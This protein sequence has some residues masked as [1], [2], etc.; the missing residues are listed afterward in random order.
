M[1]TQHMSSQ[2]KR[3][4]LSF[5]S[6]LSSFFLLI[7]NKK[8]LYFIGSFFIL[9]FFLFPVLRLLYLS[10]QSDTGLTAA[11]YTAVLAEK[12]T[13]VTLKNTIYIVS[14]STVL[15]VILG[16][17]MAWLVAYT[18]VRGKKWMQLFIF[19]PFIIPSYVITLAWVQF[20]G[21]SGLFTMF[22][23]IF[24][25]EFQ[26]FNLYSIWGIIFIMG[27]SHY[28]L[29]YLLTVTV[30]R[31][32]PRDFEH[33]SRVSGLSK[34]G[35][36]LKVSLPLALPG[37]T[38]GG[39]L[40]FLANLD[41]FGIPAFLGIPSNIKV[42]S[43]Y[44]YEQIVGF[45]P[46]AFARGAAL[47]VLLG[48]IALIGTVIQWFLLRRSKQFETVSEDTEPRIYLSNGFQKVMEGLVWLFLLTTSLIPL[49]SM[50][51]TSF[52]RAYGLEMKLENMSFKNYEFILFDSPKA[53]TAMMNSLTLAVVT[54][55]VCMIIG[56]FI[57]YMRTRQ[58]AV[59][60]KIAELF[61]SIPYAL[62]GTVLALMMIFAW[63]EPIPNWN[64]GIYGSIWILFIAYIT[65]FLFLQV[66]GSATALQQ[67]ELSV[68][69]AAQVCGTNGFYK[70]KSIL[71]PLLLPGIMS[72]AL[73]VFLFSLTELTLSSLLWSS[74]SETIGLLIFN[75][76]QAG[77]S[78][79][80]TAFSTLIVIC[81]M[82]GCI[83]SF[84]L[85]KIWSRRVLKNR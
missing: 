60:L 15:A 82:L 16:V 25:N 71:I 43:T 3:K 30:F 28:P 79:H 68:E 6:F 8:L 20:T 13:W 46:A 67:V 40:A 45:G 58:P 83:L 69:E 7:K 47:S 75:F 4:G 48:V 29:V 33:A 62:P 14:G 1:Q 18:N 27:I 63:M 59:Y 57:A 51:M 2:K 50:A 26:S 49:I 44:I 38:S 12:E 55:L 17:F 85:Q 5:S 23:N 78:T 65:R 76:E 54:A 41:N 84:I 9:V 74:G 34:T 53:K 22:L 42:L 61:I 77:Y 72:G 70:W 19:L 39:L 24:T 32:I 56:T 35:T 10:F 66:R 36:F 80:S 52:I 21:S 11:N 31:K 64:P 73:L 37:I 81:I